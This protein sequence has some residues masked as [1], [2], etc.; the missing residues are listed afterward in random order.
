MA[1]SR[2]DVRVRCPFY[3]YDECSKEQGPQITCEGLVPDSCI[4]VSFRDVDSWERH[5]VA[6]C[7]GNYVQCPVYRMLLEKYEEG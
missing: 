6:C 3:R 1:T 2:N 4:S 7:C 5:L